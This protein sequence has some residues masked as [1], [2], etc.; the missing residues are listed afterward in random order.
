MRKISYSAPAKVI[1]CGEHAVV[2]GR[3]ALV[4]AL[5]MSLNVSICGYKNAQE[6]R[7]EQKIIE[8]VQTYLKRKKIP[9]KNKKC[10]LSVN[11][12]IPIGRGL[13]S[14][15]ALSVA[16][17]AALMDF[18]T[19][20]E[21]E[22]EEINNCAYQVEK[23]YHMNPSGVDTSVSSFGGV[24]F[25]RKEFEFL[26]SISCLPLKF[27]KEIQNNM[28]L[29]DS[30]KPFETTADMVSLVGKLYNKK[31]AFTEKVLWNLER[32]TKRMIVSLMK[33]D[34]RFFK[35]TIMEAQ[36]QLE[37]LGVVS[38]TAK[39]LLDSLLPYGTGKITG[40]GGIKNGSGYILFYTSSRSKTEVFLRK[41]NITFL[42]FT[43]SLTGVQ[44]VI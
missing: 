37:L 28:I 18:F 15:S 20:H 3:P 24:V 5:D 32:T 8:T 40:A 41:N 29:I 36:R 31:T 30:G 35:D 16:S 44:K 6:N 39:H 26:K 34:V 1:L 12:G 27:P 42:S 17:S 25:F 14:S 7:A 9:Y 33:E 10:S 13:G 2:Y 4:T 38:H 43:P 23:L 11:S 22:K 19:G 21:F